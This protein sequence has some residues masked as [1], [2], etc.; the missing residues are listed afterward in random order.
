MVNRSFKSTGP[1]SQNCQK[2]SYFAGIGNHDL[3]GTNAKF[4]SWSSPAN[5]RKECTRHVK[6][7]ETPLPVC[8]GCMLHTPIVDRLTIWCPTWYYIWKFS[9]RW[10]LSVCQISCLYQKVHSL[11]EISSYAAGLPWDRTSGLFPYRKSAIHGLSVKF[12]LQCLFPDYIL[13]FN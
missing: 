1:F 4:Q 11:R 10:L 6:S 8:T 5:L 7:Q 13:I 2:G 9:Y 3:G 12:D